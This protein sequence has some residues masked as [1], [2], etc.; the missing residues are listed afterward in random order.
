M[1][2]K[3]VL[4]KECLDNL[5]IKENGIYI[6]ATLGF[7]G[8]SS[9]ILKRISK[10]HLYAFDQ[11]DFAIEK[12]RERLKEIGSNYTIIRSNFSNMKKELSKLDI[13]KVD[14]I[15]FDLGVSSV[16]LDFEERG[17]SFHKDAPLDM[18]M[19]TTAPLSAYNVLNEYSYEDL[20]RILREYGEEKYASS[21]AKNIIKARE[22]KP[23]ETTLEFV[24][25]IKKSMP[26]KEMRDKHPARRTFQAIRIE[27]NHE[28]EV[29]ETAVR[30]S[31][32]L[33]NKNG[34]L[35]IISFQSLEDKIVKN[36]FNEVSSVPNEMK[37]LPYIPEEYQP[38]FKI[39]SKGITPSKEE[40][41]ENYRAHSARLR[42]IERVKWYDEK[43]KKEKKVFK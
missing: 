1:Y 40:I 37:N 32:E 7:A 29:L 15:L 28:L 34:R 20:T 36:I 6:D 24:N 17:F 26:M 13:T 27:V 22:E 8:H 18:R 39:I 2:H 41:E 38:K 25:I 3:S 9:E 42:V 19:D 31:L 14:G 5:N 35:C 43:G 11:D 12:S 16:Q 23:I 4:L 21:I 30:Q 33:L 10:G